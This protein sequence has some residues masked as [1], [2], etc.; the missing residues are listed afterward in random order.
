MLIRTAHRT[1]T[2]Q[3]AERFAERI[4]SRLLPAG[5][6][7][8]SVRDCARQQGVSP[9]TVVAAY[10]QLLA[11]GL[12]E[13]RRQRGFYVRDLTPQI[14]LQSAPNFSVTDESPSP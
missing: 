13:S 12:V 8:P 4:R 5:A 3:L 14:Q 6:R 9:Y 11:L 2:E 1:L 10:D 7:L